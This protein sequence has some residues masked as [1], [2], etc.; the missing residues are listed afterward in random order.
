MKQGN[1]ETKS[2]ARC[3][4][5]KPLYAF[6]MTIKSK[7]Q[8]SGIRIHPW[9]QECRREHARAYARAYK[10]S[11]SLTAKGVVLPTQGRME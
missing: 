10:K 4:M 7:K 2:C 3:K 6:P 9:C 11:R 1:L 8:G 5:V